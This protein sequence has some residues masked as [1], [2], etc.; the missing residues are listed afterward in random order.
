MANTRSFLKRHQTEKTTQGN[1]NAAIDDVEV[2]RV[3]YGLYEQ[4]G[5]EEGHALDDWL[6]AVT[7]VQKQKQHTSRIVA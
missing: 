4:R 6:K 3:A 1:G 5:H 7:I 2:A